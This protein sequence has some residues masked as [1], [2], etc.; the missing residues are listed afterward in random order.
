MHRSRREATAP[1]VRPRR[2]A[3]PVLALCAMTAH[4]CLAGAVLGDDAGS[5]VES[6]A[7]AQTPPTPVGVRQV[8]SQLE[9]RDQRPGRNNRVI[10][11]AHGVSLLDRFP[12]GVTTQLQIVPAPTGDGA[13][14]VVTVRNVTTTPKSLGRIRLGIFNMG[15]QMEYFDFQ[16]SS[17]VVQGNS[18]GFVGQAFQY[19]DDFY[20]PVF[21]MRNSD[22]TVGVSIHYPI[23]EYKHDVRMEIA[24]PGNWMEQGEAGRGW[25]LDFGLSNVGEEAPH[26][27]NRHPATIA[28]NETRT[29]RV[30]VRVAFAGAPWQQTLLPYRDYFRSLYGG[31]QYQRRTDPVK[32]TTIAEAGA[33]RPQ[34][35]AGFSEMFRPDRNGWTPVINWLLEQQGWNAT[36]LWTP[37]GL[38]YN[39]RARN[40]PY[41][42]ASRL[43][44]DPELALAFDPN[45]GLRRVTQT[46]RDLGIWWGRSL[47]LAT[48]WDS[49][50]L[51][52]YDIRNQ[53]H[54]AIA[55][56]EIDEIVATGATLV[57]LDT[58]SAGVIPLWDMVAW[59]R[60][61]QQRHP[62]LS[63]VTEPSQCDILHTLAPTFV[64]GNRYID[65]D[66]P[67]RDEYFELRGP[68]FLSDFINPG[69]ETWGSFGY[70]ADYLRRFGR[71]DNA[72]IVQDV[73]RYADLGYRPMFWVEADIPTNIRAVD[74]WEFSVPAEI[75]ENDPQ[76]ANIRAGRRPTDNGP[77]PT[78]PT[79]PT[80]P[81]P[82][83]TPPTPNPDP[84]GGSGSGGGSSGSAGGSSGGSGAGSGGG[85]SGPTPPAPAPES[86]G[87]GGEPPSNPPP[88]TGSAS[89]GGEGGGG[90]EGSWGGDE[91]N[92][93]SPSTSLTSPAASGPI[94][95]TRPGARP[96]TIRTPNNRGVLGMSTPDRRRTSS[97][98]PRRGIVV[99]MNT[100][101][102]NRPAQASNQPTPRNG[103]AP[104]PGAR[105]T[106]ANGSNPT[107]ARSPSGALI[108]RPTPRAPRPAPR[109][110][111]TNLQ[112]LASNPPE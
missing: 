61:M 72:T 4:A 85:S 36:M 7:P 75:R 43:R 9:L 27:V 44:S 42:A 31:V 37:S 34:N 98:A 28:P 69:H 24:S 33:Q 46:G 39:H 99:R 53:Q 55:L 23:L 47:Q 64:W 108:A 12:V 70:K 49:D 2:Q 77:A 74:S 20:S 105:P 8:G 59:L 58:F 21:V 93:G 10:L 18:Q 79:S 110:G 5:K 6:P 50:E 63:W 80:P 90:G 51:I 106:Q 104:A 60:E 82:P 30:S 45:Q 76:I 89:G 87:A 111:I 84:N 15:T 1:T 71:P 17:R 66:S 103:A 41:Q 97:V 65:I 109:Q 96:G 26:T 67:N 35:Q 56:N 54:R 22:M 52:P 29:Y 86:G 91:G 112:N 83:P 16:H 14:V 101:A 68:N 32:G 57:G 13:D 38:Y 88:P 11:A 3:W 62:H 107:T 19:P 73:R 102:P 95:P 48:S 78:P 100:P 94:P 81:A 40:Y 92:A 25:L